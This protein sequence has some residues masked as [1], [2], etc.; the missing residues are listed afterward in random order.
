MK[1]ALALSLAANLLI[2]GVISGA[3]LGRIGS[4]PVDADGP[5]GL[6]AIGLGP[7]AFVL[8]RED[9]AALRARL[10]A[11]R[12]RLQPD[13]RGLGRSMQQVSTALRADPFDRAAMSDLLRQ[14]RGHV[15]GLQTEGHRVLL[16]QLQDM[17]PEARAALADR[18]QR[19][20]RQNR[21]P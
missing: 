14:Q 15:Q 10:T 1:I 9:R 16:D 20:M 6:R 4:G 8:D 21:S 19:R 11:D 7:L 5:M 2:I 13:L 17:T 3:A 12:S 18:L